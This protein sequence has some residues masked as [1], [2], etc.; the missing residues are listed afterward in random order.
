M[1]RMSERF[2]S[3][4]SLRQRKLPNSFKYSNPRALARRL[5]V[6]PPEKVLGVT[7]LEKA[8]AIMNR[9]ALLVAASAGLAAAMPAFAVVAYVDDFSV[10]KNG[11]MVFRDTFSDGAPPP[12]APDYLTGGPAQYFVGG[13]FAANS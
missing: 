12:S 7:Q 1:N 10:T 8:G 2:T 4:A 3:G 11:T 6:Y 9:F 5:L 13:S